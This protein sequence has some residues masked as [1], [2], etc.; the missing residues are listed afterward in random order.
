MK[1]MS[2]VRILARVMTFVLAITLLLVGCKSSITDSETQQM[3]ILL[4]KQDLATNMTIFE[5]RSDAMQRNGKFPINLVVD[6]SYYQQKEIKRGDI[7][8][9][10]L[11][12]SVVRKD[13]EKYGKKSTDEAIETKLVEIER[14]QAFRVVGLPEETVGIK[15]GQV[16]INDKILDTFYGKEYYWEQVKDKSKAVTMK[17]DVKLTPNQYFL[18]SDQWWRSGVIGPIP[19]EYI[20]GK[21]VGY[22]EEEKPN[23][24]AK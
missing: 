5:F 3:P 18:L 16:S 14:K 10:E 1:G 4:K 19:K 21:I 13:H 6:H 17:E 20:K 22:V 2:A 24:A 12:E 23:P 8:Y 11:P 9:I 7:V 15:Q